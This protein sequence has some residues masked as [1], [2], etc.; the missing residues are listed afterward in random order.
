MPRDAHGPP[1]NDPSLN[2]TP[3]PGGGPPAEPRRA[4]RVGARR[5]A[6]QLDAFAGRDVRGVAGQLELFEAS[7]APGPFSYPSDVL[8]D[9][10]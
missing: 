7:D 3:A 4:G 1:P 6:P 2:V 8:P 5:P 10:G 9:V